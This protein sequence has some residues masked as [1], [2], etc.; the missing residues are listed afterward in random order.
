L[1]GAY[2]EFEKDN[3][4][5]VAISVDP[6]EVSK[7]LKADLGL[8]FPLLS[9]VDG[10]VIGLYGLTHQGGHDDKDISRP[11]ELLLDANGVIRWAAF[12][13]SIN[14]RTHPETISEAKKRYLPA[15]AS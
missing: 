11:A 15:A 4:Q 2:G 3:L 5:V 8:P 10:K 13:E 1:A 9:D 6:P 14:A 7:K 12:S